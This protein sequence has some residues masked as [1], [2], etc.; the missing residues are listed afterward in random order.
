[1]VGA[2]LALVLML[3]RI[4]SQVPVTVAAPAPVAEPP[5]SV[6]VAPPPVVAAHAPVPAVVDTGAVLIES[7]P[8]GATIRFGDRAGAGTTPLEMGMVREGTYPVHLELEGYAP[9]DGEITINPGGR[10][11]ILANLTRLHDDAPVRMA[12]GQL[13]L[14]TTPWSRVFLGSRNLGTTPLGRVSVPSGMQRL[15][16][17]DR[18]G[19]EHRVTV[20]ITPGGHTQEFFDLRSL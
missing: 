2:A 16:L 19:N 13:S 11:N 15:R 17:V 4:V 3:P 9:W 7:R 6:A 18:D 10:A 1:L 12:P 20:R 14:N 8:N 5:H